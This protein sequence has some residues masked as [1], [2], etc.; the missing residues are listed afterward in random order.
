MKV[1]HEISDGRKAYH[2][3]YNF[4]NFWCKQRGITKIFGLS[5]FKTF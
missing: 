1:Y 5:N 4:K 3:F 2:N